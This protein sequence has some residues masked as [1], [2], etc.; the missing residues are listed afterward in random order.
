M[1][2]R[3]ALLIS[4]VFTSIS[5]AAITVD[6]IQKVYVG[7]NPPELIKRAVGVLNDG[8]DALYGK[9]FNA[10]YNKPSEP[11]FAIGPKAALDM[12]WITQKELDSVGYGGF[13]VRTTPSGVAI[14][15]K[16][17]FATIVGCEEYVRQLGHEKIGGMPVG[18]RE[19]PVTRT[20]AGRALPDFSTAYRPSMPMRNYYNRLD[21][22]RPD[23]ALAIVNP[24]IKS[25]LWIDHSAGY[26]IP[27][28]LY[29]DQHPE[30][31]ALVNGKRIAKSAFN[32]KKTPLCLSNAD[33]LRISAERALRW[34]EAQ[35]ERNVFPITYG[36]TRVWCECSNCRAL[37][38]QPG[39][40]AGRLLHWVNF[41]ADA[42]GARFPEVTI[43]TF[44]YSG[45][46][47]APNNIAPRPNV[48]MMLSSGLDMSFYAH[49][50]KIS[51]LLPGGIAKI[52]SWNDLVP[53]RVWVCEYSEKLY[54]PALPLQVEDRLN[55]YRR[56]GVSGIMYS[57]GYPDN[58]RALWS[59][60]YGRLMMDSSLSAET[61]TRDFVTRYY[62]DGGPAMAR[63]FD[64]SFARY[65]QTF[66]TVTKDTFINGH[67]ADFYS[68]DYI[69]DALDCFQEA[70]DMTPWDINKDLRPEMLYFAMDALRRPGPGAMDSQ[71][72]QVMQRLMAVVRE[73]SPNSTAAEIAA[74]EKKLQ[75]AGAIAETERPGSLEVVTSWLD[76]KPAPK[77]SRNLVYSLD[78]RGASHG[79][80]GSVMNGRGY[81]VVDIDTR[82]VAMLVKWADG[83]GLVDR[84][85]DS[86]MWYTATVGSSNYWFLTSGPAGTADVQQRYV[87]Y[88][89]AQFYGAEA[90]EPL[91]IGEG[92]VALSPMLTGLWRG[93]H[94]ALDS[95]FQVA[96][97][98]ARVDLESTRD[99]NERG[100]AHETL[101]DELRT[102][103]G[104]P[105]AIADEANEDLTASAAPKAEGIVCYQLSLSG[106]EAGNRALSNTAFAGYLVLDMATGQS[107]AV[108]GGRD[109]EGVWYTVEDWS[110]GS[111][112]FY[113]T[114]VGRQPYLLLGNGSHVAQPAR[115]NFRVLYGATRSANIGGN[116][117]QPVART[118]SGEYWTHTGVGA[119]TGI[120]AQ[121]TIR[122]QLMSEFSLSL[123]RRGLELEDAI[124]ELEQMLGATHARR[125]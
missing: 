44:A 93:G 104:V 73:L 9:R 25:D 111:R 19:V 36:D 86:S 4:L 39:H 96:T 82:Q 71:R 24:E 107:R 78:A 100:V 90:A 33:V 29:Y 92:A 37:D 49:R 18:T 26:L 121:G 5:Y 110:G 41:V 88:R 10:A 117:D 69:N 11:C 62:G 123:N 94:A 54:H 28:D 31:F 6:E 60:I 3:I 47:M 45:S 56:H 83:T 15:G 103:L 68:T 66:A 76:G 125:D 21:Q 116:D 91:E 13:V 74:L 72:V 122:G 89:Y 8:M 40:H 80:A 48:T 97:L 50:E 23:E 70:I 75:D 65:R 14:A 99:G 112:L 34:V 51:A 85:G 115:L 58:F 53:G 55:W 42:V 67:P 12:G 120:Y 113:E 87:H 108:I 119:T 102:S 84:W 114:Q 63:F 27:K 7:Q 106:L 98:A 30:Y 20:P 46:D 57:Y 61:L 95:S 16:T 101:I 32:Y 2:I 118:L 109:S 77:S 52:K 38:H 17:Y 22:A 59:H 124:V 81:L 1:S 105:A 64:I 35:P 79:G 43:V